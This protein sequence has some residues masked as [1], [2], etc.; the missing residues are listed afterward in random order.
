MKETRSVGFI[1]RALVLKDVLGIVALHFILLNIGNGELVPE[2]KDQ[3]LEFK[4]M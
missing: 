1:H 2:S 4:S 3:T